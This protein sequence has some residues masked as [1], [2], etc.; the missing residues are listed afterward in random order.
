M[1]P[2]CPHEYPVFADIRPTFG[3]LTMSAP[4]A[5]PIGSREGDGREPPHDELGATKTGAGRQ[6]CKGNFSPAQN[7][8]QRQPA[9]K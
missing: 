1:F 8:G 7:R 9:R 6:R 4:A 2:S 5:E 3:G